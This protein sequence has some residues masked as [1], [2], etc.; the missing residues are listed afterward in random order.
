[1]SALTKVNPENR[2]SRSKTSYDRCDGRGIADGEELVTQPVVRSMA[3]DRQSTQ[4]FTSSTSQIPQSSPSDDFCHD[5]SEGRG[6][7]VMTMTEEMSMSPTERVGGAMG[8]IYVP[9]NS[10][11]Q[12]VEPGRH[13]THLPTARQCRCLTVGKCTYLACKITTVLLQKKTNC[14]WYRHLRLLFTLS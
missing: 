13:V 12:R 11:S 3:A 10:G 6:A 7:I 14:G 5:P 2:Y 8:C 4:H 1:M 9:R